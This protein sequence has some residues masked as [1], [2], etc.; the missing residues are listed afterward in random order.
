MQEYSFSTYET[1]ESGSP[2]ITAPF[3]ENFTCFLRDPLT[4]QVFYSNDYNN[5]FY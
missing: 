3:K 5:Q 1:V 4:D 2:V